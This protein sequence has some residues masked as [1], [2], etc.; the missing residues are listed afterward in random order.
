MSQDPLSETLSLRPA[1]RRVKSRFDILGRATW[2]ASAL[3][4]IPVH[5]SLLV[6]LT[7]RS[8]TQGSFKT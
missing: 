6:Q 2:S 8:R 5:H 4:F 1:K 7:Y 3:G